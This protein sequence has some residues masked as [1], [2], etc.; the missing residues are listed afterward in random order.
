MRSTGVHVDLL[1]GVDR[2][3]EGVGVYMLSDDCPTV[4]AIV[5]SDA[6]EYEQLEEIIS[7]FGRRRSRNHRLVVVELDRADPGALL[8]SVHEAVA[9]MRARPVPSP[10]ASLN[11]GERPSR[12]L[13]V[14]S[15]PVPSA[16]REVVSPRAEAPSDISAELPVWDDVSMEGPVSSTDATLDPFRDSVGATPPTIQGSIPRGDEPDLAEHADTLSDV[17]DTMPTPIES[18]ST[19]AHAKAKL[20]RSRV[21][22]TLGVAVAVTAALATVGWVYRQG[23][24]DE[25]PG[26][27]T[28]VASA[29]SGPSTAGSVSDAEP[30][31]RALPSPSPSPTRAPER[32]PASAVRADE[33]A[34]KHSEPE[35]D[36]SVEDEPI[37]EIE[38]DDPELPRLELGGD[39]ADEARRVTALIGAGRIH[40][41]DTLLMRRLRRDP[42]LH[43]DAARRCA[44]HEIGGLDG[45]RLPTTG[46]LRQLRRARMLPAGVYWSRARRQNGSHLAMSRHVAGAIEAERDEPAAST[47]CVRER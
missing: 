5:H 27:D 1:P 41:L 9:D 4:F 25:D 18:L 32:R 35:T 3:L 34:G 46:E 37:L 19:G 20:G 47:L 24:A 14:R 28:R 26:P 16:A 15:A 8:L 36:E 6:I 2:D 17:Q 21:G 38:D 10:S 11:A 12:E 33:A 43:S 40:A 29:A 44:R 23:V 13:G 42:E 30:S 39:R 45:W 31:P 22:L 7:L